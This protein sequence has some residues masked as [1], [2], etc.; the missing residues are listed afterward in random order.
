MTNE[1][2]WA[3]AGGK[4]QGIGVLAALVE[5]G[6]VPSGLCASVPDELAVLKALCPAAR[7]APMPDWD[8]LD[9]IVTCRF[10]L[11]PP[12]IFGRAKWGAV[13]IHSSLLP[14]YRGVHP[15]SWAL[16]G[17]EKETGVTLHRI[18]AGVDTG[19]ILEQTA[20]PIGADDD[21]WSL[22][23]RLDQLSAEMAVAFFG[24]LKGKTAL[25]E[26][27][28]QQGPGSYAPRRLPQDGAFSFDWPARKIRDLIRA[29]PPPLPAAFAQTEKGRFSARRCEIVAEGGTPNASPGTVVGEERGFEFATADGVVRL[30]GEWD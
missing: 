14:R 24:S 12:E 6:F 27:R 5:A 10:S 26:G 13:N 22:T 30:E 29:L 9:L 28:P 1:L 25:P 19:N 2:R 7:V 8:D 11:L 4:P 21:L 15:V 23:A 16:I 20:V 18:D 17:G 3:F